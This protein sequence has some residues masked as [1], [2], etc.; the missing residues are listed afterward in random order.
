V[1]ATRRRG[2][3]AVSGARR[4]GEALRPS[5]DRH[6]PAGPS[7]PDQPVRPAGP[8]CGPRAG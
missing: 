3:D 1:V 8:R 7:N 5:G 4:P 2:P 6:E